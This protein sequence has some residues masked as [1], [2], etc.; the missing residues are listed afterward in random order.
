MTL[1]S[2]RNNE[3][4]NNWLR[5]TEGFEKD[6]QLKFK[7]GNEIHYRIFESWDS[8]KLYYMYSID[9][10]KNSEEEGK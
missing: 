1:D 4:Y 2:F 8:V 6:I 5:K 7:I 9:K 3:Y 10:L